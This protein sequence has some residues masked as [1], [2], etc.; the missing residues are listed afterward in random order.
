MVSPKGRCSQPIPPP[1]VKPATPVVETI[2]PVTASP[3]CWVCASSSPHSRPGWAQATRAA[4]SSRTAF[5][6][7]RSMT[8]PPSHV[9]VPAMLCPPPRTA[10]SRSLSRAK[11]TEA[12]TSAA[13]THRTTAAG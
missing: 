2:P 1:R 6:G 9:P 8:R 11:R 7:D 4:A 10:I 5:I 13:S 12:T 3:A